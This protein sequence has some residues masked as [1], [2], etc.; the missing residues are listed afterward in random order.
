MTPLYFYLTVPCLAHFQISINE[1]KL[2]DQIFDAGALGNFSLAGFEMVRWI[3]CT[4]K[5]LRF[6]RCSA[7]MMC[8][9]IDV[10]WVRVQSNVRQVLR[11]IRWNMSK[12][13][14]VSDLCK[15]KIGRALLRGWKMGSNVFAAR[16]PPAPG[17]TCHPRDP[18]PLFI[19]QETKTFVRALHFLYH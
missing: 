12:C 17:T 1:L 6:M 7:D 18:K 9:S 5:I 4:F 13:I 15:D 19:C 8:A 3:K 2:R 16:T 11:W 10:R 14:L